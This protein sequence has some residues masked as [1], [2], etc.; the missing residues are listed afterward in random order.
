MLREQNQGSPEESPKVTILER[1]LFKLPKDPEYLFAAVSVMQEFVNTYESR[2]SNPL[3]DT[4]RG[5]AIWKLEYTFRTDA[6]VPMQALYD[7]GLKLDLRPVK[8]L[9]ST[10]DMVF[11]MSDERI[12]QFRSLGKHVAQAC[13]ILCGVLT[14]PLPKVR[15]VRPARSGTWLYA[16][17]EADVARILELKDN[18]VVGVIGSGWPVYLAA[19][20][21]LPVVE[22]VPFERPRSWLSKWANGGYRMVVSGSALPDNLQLER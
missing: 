20:M 4:S 7:A 1:A 21:G 18:E 5:T 10:P 12:D 9:T 11:D 8:E 22:V 6:D 14:S 16:Y 3:N 17:D 13:G 19:S 2:M 15:I